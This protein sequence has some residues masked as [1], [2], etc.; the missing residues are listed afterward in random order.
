MSI[1]LMC[2]GGLFAANVSAASSSDWIRTDQ[3]NLRLISER[4]GVAGRDSVRI[5]LQIKLAPG[6]K[7]YWRTPGDAGIPPHFDWVG[8]ENLKDALVAWPLPEAFETYG[9]T[10]WGYHDE[11]VFP[12][13]VTLKEAGEPL[14][15][16]LRL[17]LGICENICIPYEHAFTLA[18][19]AGTAKI[20]KEAAIIDQYAKHVP[21]VIGTSGVAISRASAMALNDEDF[22]VTAYTNSSFDSPQIIIEGIEGAYFELLSKDV[23]QDRETANFI[24][25]ANLPAKTDVL[26]SQQ[27]VVTISDKGKAAQGPLHIE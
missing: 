11:V 26:S 22:R 7:T 17:Q 24:L 21:A 16:K 8:S 15:L 1:M 2:L 14:D 9:L 13:D 25:K 27:I 20:S 23:S 5:G 3:S 6:W 19:G 12:I 18:L 4:D 10:S